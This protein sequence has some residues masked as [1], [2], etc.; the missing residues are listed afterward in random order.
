MNQKRLPW[1]PFLLFR[2]P[3][4]KDLKAVLFRL[5]Q[6]SISWFVY[7]GCIMLMRKS[8]I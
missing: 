5:L 3:E 1:G 8:K 2:R 7:F 4:G 6:L